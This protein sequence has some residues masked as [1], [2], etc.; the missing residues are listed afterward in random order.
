MG[1][2][3]M[4]ARGNFPRYSYQLASHYALEI[5]RPYR[6]ASDSSR[7]VSCPA[8]TNDPADG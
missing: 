2:G 4:L 3:V 6:P 8:E 5:N 7:L 1:E